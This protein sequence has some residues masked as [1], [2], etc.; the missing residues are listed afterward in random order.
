VGTA[1]N[2]NNIAMFTL[3]LTIL[4]LL[5]TFIIR[6]EVV[7]HRTRKVV[8]IEVDEVENIDSTQV[9]MMGGRGY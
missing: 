4:T 8:K 7:T 2:A 5:N 9:R 1:G 6:P 3:R